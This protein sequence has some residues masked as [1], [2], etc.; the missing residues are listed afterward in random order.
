MSNLSLIIIVGL[1]GAFILARL[2]LTL[3]NRMRSAHQESWDEKMIERLRAKGY[4]PFN[5]YPIA[6]FLALPDEASCSAVRARL[7]P[8]GFA[9]DVKPMTAQLF[10]QS[11][12]EVTLPLSLH[13]TKTMRLLVVDMVELSRRLSALAAEFNGRYDG[14]AV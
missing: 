14:W 12:S 8:D 2:Y 10:G 5:E 6:F 3:R 9:V 7:E 4:A 11:E 13:A 1:V